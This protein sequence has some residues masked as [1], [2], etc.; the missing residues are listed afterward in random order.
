MSAPQGQI[1]TTLGWLPAEKVELRESVTFEDDQIRMVRIDKYVDG[2][3]V[4]NDLNGQI[5]TGHEFS[6][7]AQ[8]L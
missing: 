8:P 3:W 6:V 2:T 4:G 5:K 7:I 1:F